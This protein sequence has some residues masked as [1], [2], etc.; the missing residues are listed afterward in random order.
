M[1]SHK[2]VELVFYVSLIVVIALT[3]TFI[4]LFSLYAIYKRKNITNGHE[5]DEILSDL[6]KKYKIEELNKD[7]K[8][9]LESPSG[10]SYVIESN[11]NSLTDSKN[12]TEVSFNIDDVSTSET[13]CKEV[14]DNDTK[15]VN[16]EKINKIKLVDLIKKQEKKNKIFKTIG[17]VLSKVL[18]VVLASIIVVAL[19]Y[20]GNGNQFFIGNTSYLV[21]QTSSMESVNEVN[22]YIKDNKL[23]NQIIQFSMI[24]VDKVDENDIKLYDILAFTNSDGDTIVHR[25][26][27]INSING[28]ITYTLR[29]DANNASNSYEL[30]VK[31][32][33]IV[34]RYNGYQNYGLGV[35]TTYFKSTAG[36]V[37]IVSAL[38]FLILFE[39][40]ETLIDEDYEA[41]RLIVAKKYDEEDDNY[42][43]E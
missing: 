2:L 14:V 4:M 27:R 43:E 41:R 15:E 37:A 26:T 9:S 10:D 25:V 16:E 7:K 29:G 24:G 17:N 5:D 11:S 12:Q 33:Q 38:V 39:I 30:S 1:G 8:S 20:K 40:S 42:E 36:I 3:A 34:G 22:T 35:A 18:F 19:A 21:I 31:Y 6:K 28:E 32:S 13:Y 23:D